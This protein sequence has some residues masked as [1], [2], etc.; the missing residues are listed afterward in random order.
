MF[1][2]CILSLILQNCTDLLKV[3]L[4]SCSEACLTSCHDGNEVID[5]KV[6]EVVDR[7]EEEDP[8]LITFPVIKAEH[9]VSSVYL[10]SFLSLMEDS[11]S[12]L[13]GFGPLANYADRATAACWRSNA[14]FCG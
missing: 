6:E 9:E 5:I 12:L 7:E 4:G 8:L 11:Y 10:P 3:E 2:I 14:N 13:R 1:I